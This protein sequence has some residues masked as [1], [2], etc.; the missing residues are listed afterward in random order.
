MKKGIFFTARVHPGETNSSFMIQGAIDYL[1]SDC[2]EAKILRKKCVFKI[3]PMLNPD[4]VVYGNYRCS[5]LGVDLNR[6]WKHPHPVLHPTIYYAKKLVKILSREREIA[7]FC[8]FHGHSIKK[9]TFMY[10]CANRNQTLKNNKRNL[11][12]RLIPYM[13]SRINPNFSYQ[14]SH[15]RIEKSKQSTAR[16]SNFKDHSIL[17]SYTLEASFFGSSSSDTHYTTS[18]LQLIGQDLCSVCMVFVSQKLFT[19]KISEFSQ[20]LKALKL[21][22][23]GQKTSEKPE[24]DQILRLVSV[25][26]QDDPEDDPKMFSIGNELEQIQVPEIEDL[27]LDESSDSGG[28]DSQ[29]SLNDEK[30]IK[31]LLR[32][33]K[34]MK[35]KIKSCKSPINESF[36]QINSCSQPKATC[37]SPEVIMKFRP[38]SRSSFRKRSEVVSK[39]IIPAKIMVRSPFVE[40]NSEVRSRSSLQIFQ[41]TGRSVFK[42]VAPMKPLK[43]FSEYL[44]EIDTVETSNFIKDS[45]KKV[46]WRIDSVNA[47]TRF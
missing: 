7:L 9:N 12:I 20:Y 33:S 28:S 42:E 40:E 5:L 21:A 37:A 6:R 11:L 8:D 13:L 14:S 35:K 19:S 32:K 39:Q 45:I 46:K 27:V 41:T 22:K 25:T 23:S 1:L 44:K 30:K 24:P 10:G 26:D 16:I 4:G 34:K 36:S 18:D 29:A 3:I 38:K 47:F 31:F 43:K 2:K 15:F 17:A